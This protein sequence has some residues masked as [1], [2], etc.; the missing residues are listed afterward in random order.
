MKMVLHY[1][2]EDVSPCI[3][4]TM[5]STLMPLGTHVVIRPEATMHTD[6]VIMNVPAIC[7]T[8]YFVTFIDK[9]SGHLRSFPMK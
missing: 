3:E 9:A 5:T 1:L 6:V 2:P 8:R 7:E 4:G